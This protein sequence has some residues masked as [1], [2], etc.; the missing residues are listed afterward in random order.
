M[1]M[2]FLLEASRAGAD[3]MAE[4]GIDFKYPSYVQDIM[5]PMCFDYGF[6]PFRWVCASGN[7]EDLAKTDAIAC[8]VLEDSKKR[9]SPE[10]Q[11]QMTDNIQW[12]KG[13]QAHKLV[14]GSQA[15]ILYADAEGRMKI[16]EAFNTAIA[17]RYWLCDLGRDH[18]DVS[19]TDSPYRETSNIYDGSQ[20][21][22]DMAIQNVIGDSFEELLG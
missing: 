2:H 9:S 10:I 16:A 12:I 19:G 3:I 20:F 22:A 18:H 4:N 7:P 6:G 13:A 17:K 15:R 11:Q 1:E 5:G 8:R 14:V 21:T